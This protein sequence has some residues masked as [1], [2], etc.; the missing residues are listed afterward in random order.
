MEDGSLHLQAL[1]GAEDL[2]SDPDP[3]EREVT[4]SHEDQMRGHI[5]RQDVTLSSEPHVA[6]VCCHSRKQAAQTHKDS[7]EKVA[8]ELLNQ[9]GTSGNYIQQRRL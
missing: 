4:G 3:S 1:V 7:K 6:S 9:V 8:C 2:P 5:R